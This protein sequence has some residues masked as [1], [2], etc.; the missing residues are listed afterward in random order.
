[1][2]LT[3]ISIDNDRLARLDALAA[4]E[5]TSREALVNQAI[6]DLLTKAD[7]DAAYE[8]WFCRKVQEGLQACQEG[9][10]ISNDDSK[11]RALARRER[12]LA[13]SGAC[14]G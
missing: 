14:G 1:M 11:R 12:L 7:T 4:Q 8:A 9:R 6:D 10:V 5:S 3:Q 2:S 13:T